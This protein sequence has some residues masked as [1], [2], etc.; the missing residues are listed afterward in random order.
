MSVCLARCFLEWQGVSFHKPPQRQFQALAAAELL[1]NKAVDHH[2]TAPQA[3]LVLQQFQ[4]QQVIAFAQRCHAV[5][6]RG[7]G[8]FGH[9]LRLA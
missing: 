3:A 2:P 4:H 1:G 9:E 7:G 5:Q 6:H 8:G